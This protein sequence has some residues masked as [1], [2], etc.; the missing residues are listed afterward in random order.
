MQEV[1]MCYIALGLLLL[2]ALAA[3]D[4]PRRSLQLAGAAVIVATLAFLVWHLYAS[5]I[6]PLLT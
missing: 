5:L 4:S 1:T 3:T 2:A 6:H